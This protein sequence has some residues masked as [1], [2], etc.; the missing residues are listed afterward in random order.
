MI[1]RHL[2]SHEPA[3]RLKKQYRMHPIL[4]KFPNTHTYGG[5]LEDDETC[6]QILMDPRVE[7]GLRSWL[8]RQDPK[9]RIKPDSL[10]LMGI[11][12]Q[13]GM[14]QTHQRTTPSS[15]QQMWQ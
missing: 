15:T 10:R 5:Q 14:V 4:A 13:G 9:A 8:L 3:G 11:N 2:R 12:V 6:H 7:E 1:D